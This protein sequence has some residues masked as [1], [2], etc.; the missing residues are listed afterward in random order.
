MLLPLTI[1][2]FLS[3]VGGWIGTPWFDAFGHFLEPVLP[4]AH[5]EISMGLEVTLMVVAFALAAAG[6]YLAFQMHWKKLEVPAQLLASKPFLARIH[7]VLYRK[8]YV[9]E[10]YDAVLVRPIG[11]ISEKFLFRIVDANII[12]GIVND[13]ASILRSIG[14]GFRRLQTGDARSYAAAILIGTLGLLAYFVWMVR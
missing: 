1:L 2:A 14:G 11:L 3:V 13:T 6:I 7:Q 8:Y 4:A 5:H 10:I 12:D 9:D